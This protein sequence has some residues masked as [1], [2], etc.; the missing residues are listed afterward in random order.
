MFRYVI[1]HTKPDHT[2][3]HTHDNDTATASQEYRSTGSEHQP[4][5]PK[6]RRRGQNKHRPRAARLAFSKML[7]PSLHDLRTPPDANCATPLSCPFKEKCRYTHNIAKFMSE[8]LPDIGERCYVF[9]TYGKC[10][11]GASCRFGSGHMTSDF[12][13]VVK[14]G[15]YD[16]A[17]LPGQ[18]QN[19]L[20]K[21]LQERLRKKQL[22]F[23]RSERY[24]QRLRAAR[25]EGTMAGGVKEEEREGGDGGN[26][27]MMVAGAGERG[28]CL[29]GREEE[30]EGVTVARICEGGGDDGV[31]TWTGVVTDEGE[32][33]LRQREKRTVRW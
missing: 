11:Y 23:E 25:Q 4:P 24:L 17:H 9:E 28:G 16:P 27:D 13:N 20:S 22:V 15:V 6:K 21:Q 29:A 1:P 26:S 12:V 5:Q 3:D 18:T 33:K 30:M 10:P 19:L 14:E 7:C 32:I 31:K 8:K 2:Q